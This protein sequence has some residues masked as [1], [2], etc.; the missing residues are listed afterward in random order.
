MTSDVCDGCCGGLL[1]LR[2]GPGLLQYGILSTTTGRCLFSLLAVL[3][4][5]AIIASNLIYNEV[6]V[7][8]DRYRDRYICQ[9]ITVEMMTY[10][11]KA[12]I[13]VYV[14]LELLLLEEIV[15]NVLSWLLR[16][17]VMLMISS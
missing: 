10:Q 5:L 16:K 2:F 14:V 13:Y 15:S 6:K 4:I 8:M 12:S 1:L 11:L 3:I 7:P 17:N 9:P